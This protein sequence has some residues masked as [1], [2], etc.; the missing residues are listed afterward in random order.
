MHRPLAGHGYVQ[1]FHIVFNQVEVVSMLFQVNASVE[2]MDLVGVGRHGDGEP[3]A[4]GGVDAPG[5]GAEVKGI[6]LHLAVL[7]VDH[8]QGAGLPVAD[9]QA[10]HD[11]AGVLFA[12][13]HLSVV[14]MLPH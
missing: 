6:L 10:A 12:S 8:R 13:G 5:P 11:F 14:V 4:A 1:A 2:D 9:E 3:S 7:Q